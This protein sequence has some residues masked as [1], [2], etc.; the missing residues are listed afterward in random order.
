MQG[1]LTMPFSLTSEYLLWS[2]VDLDYRLGE[3]EF[4]RNYAGESIPVVRPSVGIHDPDA[5]SGTS[6]NHQGIDF[7]LNNG[8]LLLAMSNGIVLQSSDEFH[9]IRIG[10]YNG[11]QVFVVGYGHNTVNVLSDGDTVYRGQIVALSGDWNN[12]NFGGTNPHVHSSLW[13]IPP[14]WNDN[15]LYYIFDSG[16]RMTIPYSS[17][18]GFVW[19]V[20]DPY[21]DVLNSSSMSY[22]TKDNDPQFSLVQLGE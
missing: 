20:D 13:V 15:P 1:F 18:S 14:K 2:Y 17:S 11:S 19:T 12:G 3:N 7:Y 9:C 4:I 22:W 5:R 8:S 6:D 10:H 16:E 21:R